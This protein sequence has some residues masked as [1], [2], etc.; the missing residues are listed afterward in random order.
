MMGAVVQSQL[1]LGHPRDCND[2]A[3]MS[4]L[5][6]KRLSLDHP[7]TTAVQTWCRRCG[8]PVLLEVTLDYEYAKRNFYALDDQPMSHKHLHGETG[9]WGVHWRLDEVLVTL[10]PSE[11][12]EVCW[13][14]PPW[15]ESTAAEDQGINVV[16][17]NDL[18]SMTR[19][20]DVELKTLRELM[21]R[22]PR[23]REELTV[24]VAKPVYDQDELRDQYE[25]LGFRAPFVIVRERGS[26]RQGSMIFQNHPRFYFSFQTDRVI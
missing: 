10:F 13:P 21:D 4:A 20:V 25:V 16:N 19:L 5:T 8:L 3:R 12:L 17:P 15:Y 18:A 14:K 6:R 1:D 2:C 7:R 11:H 24:M 26:G 23:S 9:G 22:H